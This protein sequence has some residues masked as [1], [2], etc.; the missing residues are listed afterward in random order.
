MFTWMGWSITSLT[1]G[2]LML[3]LTD[4]PFWVGMGVGVR[5]AA[6]AICS[7]PGG[8][9][10]D[11]VDRRR[12]LLLTQ[13]LMAAISFGLAAL[14]LAGAARV[15]HVLVFMAVLGMLAAVDRPGT[16]GLFYDLA[17]PGRMLSAS[18][19]K[20]I[21]QATTNIVASLAGG[22]VLQW[23]GMGQNMVLV[24]GLHATAAAALL[25][26]RAP[27]AVTNLVGPLA[28]SVAEG[29][30]YARRTP[31][32]R[33]LLNLSL[34]TESFG[35]ASLTMMPV[36]ARDVLKVGGLGLG[37]LTAAGGVGQLLATVTLVARGDVR[38]KPRLLVVSAAA[39]GL[40]IAA[41]GLSRSPLLS[42]PLAMVV[43]ACG[44]TY[45]VT[46]FALLPVLASDAMRGRVLGLF[47]A[48]ISFSQLGG[49]VAGAAA[50][51]VGAPVALVASGLVA[52]A[53]A[54]RLGGS[55]R[56][57]VASGEARRS[58]VAATG[59]AAPLQETGTDA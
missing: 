11:R 10:A 48:T 40:L 13:L 55:L 24:G 54:L 42:L 35:F 43:Y 22:A 19:V 3:H 31:P 23:L 34:M 38:D 20:F 59:S 17:G 58:A 7:L 6:Q 25:I 56:G 36:I 44:I 16:S 39:F 5:G 28:R 12:L 33:T 27:G 53:G 46:M 1:H 14:V 41:F 47:A 8:A 26:L 37:Y 32:V 9:L 21:G 49:L 45:D 52:A 4:S 2:W 29:I 18:A 30:H 50:A 15:G 51:A 57:A